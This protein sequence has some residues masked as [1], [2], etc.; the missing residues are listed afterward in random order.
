MRGCTA[1]SAVRFLNEVIQHALGDFEVGD[2]AIIHGFDGDDIAGCAPEHLFRLFADG[3]YFAV[4]LIYGH[5]G[6]FVDDD[7]LTFGEDQRVGRS[8]VNRKVRR[9]Q[10]E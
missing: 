9:K 7:S 8:E 2:N 1:F 10:T 6:G 3:L 4:V 5:D